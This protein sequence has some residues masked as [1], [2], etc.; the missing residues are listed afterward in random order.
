MRSR[1]VRRGCDL[2]NAVHRPVH[3]QASLTDC[4][5]SIGENFS[6]SGT[7]DDIRLIV[8]RSETS[9]KEAFKAQGS[10]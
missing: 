6:Y 8:R 2:I 1:L 10:I 3:P 9:E 4:K 5:Y 7:M